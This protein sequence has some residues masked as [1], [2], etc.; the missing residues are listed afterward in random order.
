MYS[1]ITYI[2]ITSK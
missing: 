1:N 2:Q